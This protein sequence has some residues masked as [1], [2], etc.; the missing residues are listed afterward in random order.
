MK[1]ISNLDLIISSQSLDQV[2]Q[3]PRRPVRVVLDNIR[4]LYNVGSIFRTS[5][6]AGVEK[7][8]VCG[9]TGQ[10]PRAEIHKAALGAESSVPWEYF[11]TPAP[12]LNRLKS[13]GF[14]IVVLEHTDLRQPYHQAQFSFPLCLVIGHE[15]TG[16]SDEAVQL[17]DTAIEI[18]MFGLK[19]SL[20]VSVAY[21][22]AIY[23]IMKQCS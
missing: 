1:K 6:A 9:I 13:E 5:D 7:L 22:I 20:N 17:A 4:S 21:G 18:P 2:H 14:S 11:E 10:P 15:I 8:Y 23:E 19:Q 3:K 12:V 16:V